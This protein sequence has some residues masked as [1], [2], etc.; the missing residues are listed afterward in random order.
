MPCTT[1]AA[2]GPSKLDFSKSRLDNVFISPSE[3]GDFGPAFPKN[4]EMSA[5][6]L[7]ES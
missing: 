5:R 3:T 2:A 1:A 4:H 6:F 7:S